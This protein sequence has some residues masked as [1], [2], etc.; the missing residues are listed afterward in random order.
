MINIFLI[1]VNTLVLQVIEFLMHLNSIYLMK[2]SS[3]TMTVVQL[4]VQSMTGIIQYLE[5]ILERHLQKNLCL[6]HLGL[7]KNKFFKL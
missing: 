6:N 2:M 4:I 3:L 5:A 7:H 1:T